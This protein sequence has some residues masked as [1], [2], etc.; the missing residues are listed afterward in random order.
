MV[1][2]PNQE[3]KLGIIAGLEDELKTL[4]KWRHHK[5]VLAGAV[6]G[7]P[8]RARRS[9]D[10]MWT[11]GVRL[12]LSWGTA[13]ALAPELRPGD[14]IVPDGVVLPVGRVLPFE[15]ER[16]PGAGGR[17]EDGVML[18]AGA[19]RP[20]LTAEGKAALRAETGAVA[21]DMESHLVAHAAEEAAFPAVAI[22]AIVDTAETEVP[23]F[24]FSSIGPDGRPRMGKLLMGLAAAPQ[25]TGSLLRLR[26]DYR[27]A[28]DALRECA[29]SDVIKILVNMVPKI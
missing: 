21:V 5:R 25:R 27:R 9:I 28:L 11:E 10:R 3:P 7:N 12:L 18:M 2:I 6:V 13:G 22:R 14:L 4:G 19:T 16:I 20:V 24:A 15:T 29:D 26:R 1:H 23:E 8:T 17:S